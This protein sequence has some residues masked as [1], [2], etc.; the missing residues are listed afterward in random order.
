MLARTYRIRIEDKGFDA[1]VGTSILEKRSKLTGQDI[2]EVN[3]QRAL[4]HGESVVET[5]DRLLMF[6]RL[7]GVT[8]FPWVREVR[9]SKLKTKKILNTKTLRRC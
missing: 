7:R 3:W 6:P 8:I 9:L 5:N 2:N 1:R 4:R